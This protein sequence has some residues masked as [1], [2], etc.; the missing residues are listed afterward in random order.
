MDKDAQHAGRPATARRVRVWGE[1]WTSRQ[2]VL[3]LNVKLHARPDEKG[4]ATTN[5]LPGT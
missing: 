5:R 2:G 4:I 1:R 3:E